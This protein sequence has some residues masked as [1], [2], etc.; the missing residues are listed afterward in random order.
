VTAIDLEA[1]VTF[2]RAKQR[3]QFRGGQLDDGFARLTDEVLMLFVREVIDGAS[4]AEMHVV[5]HA[6][7]LER[8]ERSIDGRDV[9]GREPPMD[10]GGEFFGGDV[11]IGGEHGL[12]DHLTR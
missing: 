9:D 3:F 7:L 8:V 12:D 4:V 6:D 10:V 1:V 2:D 5:Y 11:S